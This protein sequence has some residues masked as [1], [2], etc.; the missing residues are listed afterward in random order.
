MKL[1]KYLFF[2]FVILISSCATPKNDADISSIRIYYEE[3]KVQNC[4]FKSDIVGSDGRWFN[5][6]FISNK[7]LT[8]NALND[9]KFTALE[10][11]ADSIFI[12][13]NIQFGTSVTFIGQAFKC[14]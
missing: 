4:V 11:G 8:Y 14:L 9:L 7:I 5:F 13:H 1:P 2:S 12:H 10:A 6:L 3:N